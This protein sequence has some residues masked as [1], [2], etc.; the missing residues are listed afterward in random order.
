VV[1]GQA[2]L[3]TLMVHQGALKSGRLGKIYKNICQQGYL[4]KTLNN[5]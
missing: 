2:E 3:S 4:V 5:I 1:S